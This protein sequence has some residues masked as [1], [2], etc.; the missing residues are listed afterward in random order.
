MP[1]AG[2]VPSPQQP[3]PPALVSGG[4]PPAQGYQPRLPN[5][6]IGTFGGGTPHGGGPARTPLSL[7]GITGNKSNGKF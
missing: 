5:P 3:F 1:P 7:P 6:D 2:F 4:Q